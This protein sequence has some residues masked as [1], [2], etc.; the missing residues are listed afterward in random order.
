MANTFPKWAVPRKILFLQLYLKMR[1]S[2]VNFGVRLKYIL[3]YLVKQIFIKLLLF[4]VI[5]NT[6]NTFFIITV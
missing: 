1:L 6:N 5:S 4:F 3:P 2:A